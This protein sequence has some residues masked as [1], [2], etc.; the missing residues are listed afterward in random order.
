VIT[1][2]SIKVSSP[3]KFDPDFRPPP[4]RPNQ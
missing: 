2:N 1:T 4:Y 3:S